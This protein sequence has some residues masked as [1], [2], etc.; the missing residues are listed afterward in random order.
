[1][2]VAWIVQRWVF[3]GL[4]SQWEIGRFHRQVGASEGRERDWA[5]RESSYRHE[6]RK[7]AAQGVVYARIVGWVVVQRA[8]RKGMRRGVQ[9]LLWTEEEAMPRPVGG[10]GNLARPNR[11]QV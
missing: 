7:T 4:T 10:D 2:E 9:V 8:S 3:G 6:K 5:A 11:N 1:M